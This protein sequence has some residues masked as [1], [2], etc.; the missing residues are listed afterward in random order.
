MEI[1]YS[2][3]RGLRPVAEVNCEARRTIGVLLVRGGGWGV[4]RN[5]RRRIAEGLLAL[6]QLSYP[7]DEW[8]GQDSNLRPPEWHSK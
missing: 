7:P 3:D 2:F 6:S 4:D 8:T 1:T 5:R